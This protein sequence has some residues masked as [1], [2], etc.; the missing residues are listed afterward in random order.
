MAKKRDRSHFFRNTFLTGLVILV[1]IFVTYI[2]VTFLIDLLSGVGA[3]ILKGITRIVGFERV[4]WV[5]PFV[6]FFN[7]LLSLLIILILGLIGTNIFGRKLLAKFNQLVMRLPLVSSIYGAAKQVVETF[8]GP[9]QSFQ[10]VVLVEF[11]HK[12]NW[13]MGLVACE[14]DDS[15]QLSTVK[16]MYSVFIPTTPNPT[17]GFLILVSPKDVVELDYDVEEAFKYIVSSGILG[18]NLALEKS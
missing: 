2:L 8:H 12:G 7:F 16:K 5:E 13:M 18:R 3:P 4:G 15:L 1:P 17:S 11:P 9:N 6:P 10:K 14:R